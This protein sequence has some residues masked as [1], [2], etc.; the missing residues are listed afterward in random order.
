MIVNALRN[1]DW[2]WIQ[3]YQIKLNGDNLFSSIMS[4]KA[5]SSS[6][7]IVSKRA[8]LISGY[9]QI[10][11]CST[12]F[13]WCITICFIW[14]CQL[15]CCESCGLKRAKSNSIIFSSIQASSKTTGIS[16]KLSLDRVDLIC[17][18]I[19]IEYVTCL[20]AL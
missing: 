9:F 7:H 13:L 16:L 10:G 18:I 17:V 11:C 12:Q 3:T 15:N 4:S 19:T 14:K 5:Q 2:K 8:D 6:I 1:E 20:K